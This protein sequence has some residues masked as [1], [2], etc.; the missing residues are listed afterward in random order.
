MGTIDFVYIYFVYAVSRFT[1]TGVIWLCVPYYAY[2]AVEVG[3]VL[4]LQDCN[5]WSRDRKHSCIAIP[6]LTEIS[7]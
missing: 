5:P 3:A 1:A 7:W 2:A 6:A 4:A